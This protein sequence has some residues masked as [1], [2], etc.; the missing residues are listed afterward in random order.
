MYKIR[1][2]SFEGPLHLLLKLIEQEKLDINEVSLS[3]IAD[4]YLL[5]IKRIEGKNPEE[6]ADFLV[7][8]AKLILIKSKKLLPNLDLGLDEDEES[9]E[10]QLKMYREFVLA[11]ENIREIIEKKNFT[12]SRDRYIIRERVF[13]PPESLTKERLEKVFYEII[14]LIKPIIKLPERA[15]KR[16]ISIQEKINYI[17][18]LISQK[19]SFAF[20]KILTKT[21]D[22]TEKIVSFL[23]L[24]ELTKQR[25]VVVD[26]KNI[27]E[28]IIIKKYE[29]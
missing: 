16:A 28:N 18:K 3:Q 10:E 19:T 27:F 29:S 11:S 17:Q 23:A 9:L 4:Q 24:L 12:F 21:K 5:Y 14:S 8:A 6:M 13:S 1:T 7:V 15:L 2:D 22:K 20:A 25:S 26:Q